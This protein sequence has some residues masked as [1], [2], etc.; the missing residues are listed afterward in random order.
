M[1]DSIFLKCFFHFSCTLSATH[2]RVSSQK[3]KTDANIK[4]TVNLYCDIIWL[5]DISLA[6]LTLLG[7]GDQASVI[8]NPP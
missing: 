8:S 4:M 3:Q 2:G 5:C 1:G 7:I 6:T